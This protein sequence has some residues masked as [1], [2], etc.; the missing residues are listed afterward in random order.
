M[1]VDRLLEAT[2]RAERRHFWFRGFRRFIRPVLARA[3]GSRSQARILDCGCGTGANLAVLAD[4]GRPFGFDLTWTGLRFARGAGRT[5]IARAS[6]AHLPFGDASFDVVTSFDVL[7][8]VP[9]HVE[10]DAAAEM[11]RVLKPGGAA[12]V[13][14]SAF[15]MLRGN[16]AVLSSEFR[17]YD[18]PRVRQL[19]E[20]AGFQ[21][22]HLTYTNITLFPVMLVVRAAQRLAGLKQAEADITVPAAPINAAL[23]GLLA[24]EA[25]IAR[26][27]PLP[28]GSSLLCVARKRA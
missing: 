8:C 28:F 4:F 3:V 26:L 20:G 25:Q 18:R 13:N 6:V 14:V 16:H 12:V 10:V 15:D 5:R 19:L 21:I 17:R 22:E 9:D 2:F 11:A 1:S 24:A 7:Q 27:M 23:S